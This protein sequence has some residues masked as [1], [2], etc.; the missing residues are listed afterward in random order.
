M[1]LKKL[2]FFFKFYEKIGKELCVVVINLNYM[3][4]EYCYVKIILD[5]FIRLVVCMFMVILGN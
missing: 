4:E 2:F 5:M 3:I 1:N